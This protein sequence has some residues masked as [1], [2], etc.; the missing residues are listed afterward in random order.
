MG[1]MP[2]LNHERSSTSLLWI[3]VVCFLIHQNTAEDTFLGICVVS[4]YNNSKPV[5]MI[6][7]V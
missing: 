3:K 6:G 1:V 7:F 4:L 5:Q 2:F